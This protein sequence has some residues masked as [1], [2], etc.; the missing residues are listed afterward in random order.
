M[1]AET[2]K[3]MLMV[4]WVVDWAVYEKK[5]VYEVEIE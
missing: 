5:G 4:V 3:R 1:M 2:V